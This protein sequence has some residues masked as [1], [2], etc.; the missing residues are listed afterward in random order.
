MTTSI[1]IQGD[2]Y[3]NKLSYRLILEECREMGWNGLDNGVTDN[4]LSTLLALLF[5]KQAMHLMF[6][7]TSPIMKQMPISMKLK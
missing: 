7:L 6:Q 1:Y 4:K 5:M 2:Y 3:A